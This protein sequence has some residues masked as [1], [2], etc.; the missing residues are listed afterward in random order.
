MDDA[1][2]E[3]FA[4]FVES[5]VRGGRH[6]NFGIFDG[7]LCTRIIT[8]SLDRHQQGLGAARSHRASDFVIAAEQ[9]CGHRNDLVLELAQ[10]GKSRGVET[11]LREEHGVGLFEQVINFIRDV[12]DE[13]ENA[14]VLPL[15]VMVTRAAHGCENVCFGCA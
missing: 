15:R 3:V 8:R 10:A 4:S 9:V 12:I 6:D 14:S 2:V 13:S 1:H 11:V 5:G 7:P